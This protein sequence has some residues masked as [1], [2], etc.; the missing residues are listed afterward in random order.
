MAILETALLFTAILVSVGSALFLRSAIQHNEL[1]DRKLRDAEQKYRQEREARDSAED[2]LRRAAELHRQAQNEVCA[3]NDARAV[4]IQ[5]RDEANER[6]QH[7]EELRM[8]AERERDAANARVRVAEQARTRAEEEREAAT[9]ERDEAIQARKIAEENTRRAIQARFEAEDQ[10]R[11]ANER[12]QRAEDLQKQAE[13]NLR[14]AIQD[15]VLA[16]ARARSFENDAHLAREHASQAERACE[17]A[18]EQARLAAQA[19]KHAEDVRDA[20]LEQA[21]LANERANKA[22]QERD[23]ALAS[24]HRA[25][26]RA[27]RAEELRKQAERERDKANERAQRAERRARRARNA[28][29]LAKKQRDAANE[30]AEQA[31]REFAEPKRVSEPIPRVSPEPPSPKPPSGQG[32]ETNKPRQSN[33]EG[34]RKPRTS[35]SPLESR[36]G[37]RDHEPRLHIAYTTRSPKPEI[38]CVQ[39]Q[40]EWIL[41]VELPQEWL[42]QYTDL[43][44]FQNGMQLEG[45]DGYWRLNDTQGNLVVRSDK[46]SVWHT[47]LGERAKQ[48]LLFKLCGDRERGQRVGTV[49]RGWYLLVV[50]ES[51]Q[52][53]GYDPEGIAV[54]GYQAYCRFVDDYREICFQD[55]DGKSISLTPHVAQFTLDGSRLPDADESRGPLFGGTLPHLRAVNPDAWQ[56]V[57]TVVVGEEGRKRAEWRSMVFAPDTIQAQQNLPPAIVQ[58]KASWFFVRFYDT[59]DQLIESMDFRLARGLTEIQVNPPSP[60]P[61]EQGH[62]AASVKFYHAADCTIEP[63]LDIKTM[64]ADGITIAEIPPCAK[65]AKTCWNITTRDHEPIQVTILVERIWWA[66]GMQ[67]KTLSDSEWSDK[68]LALARAD[69]IN[70]TDKSLWIRLPEP[71][72]IDT[73]QVL[74][75]FAQE[76]MRS[77]ARGKGSERIASIRLN[78]FCDSESLRRIGESQ[79]VIR[80]DDS[81]AT[82]ANVRAQAKCRFCDFATDAAEKIY[83]HIELRHLD[84]IFQPLTYAEHRQR[85][86]DLPHRIAICL[87]TDCHYH[88]YSY[89]PIENVTDLIL[90][91]I[92]LEKHYDQDGHPRFEELSDV[93]KI[94]DRLPELIPDI[95]KCALHP[96]DWEKENPSKNDLLQHLKENHLN[97][98]YELD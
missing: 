69:F 95:R 49:S 71:R 86:P 62:S 89:S 64:S 12:A 87:R 9:R 44:V 33:N 76:T 96:C 83:S 90:Q 73:H 46:E 43:Q 16:D 55:S 26:E 14:L 53:E 58:W 38:T 20:A 23:D 59:N 15:K 63:P 48:P 77:L 60:L 1:A 13:E 42:E 74:V 3:A 19:Q 22:E 97:A 25:N 52:Y 65:Y 29:V 37:A 8:R 94:R 56:Q 72:W 30:R 4:A 21:R 41:R 98:L 5:G 51:W 54:P 78:D 10:T 66:V 88:A 45:T 92:R 84:A 32:T 11:L 50:P 34:A 18:K 47:H 93:K 27:Q 6:A 80:V 91:H 7:A 67:G 61:E 85:N 31:E 24:E 68:P 70:V 57:K 79:F 40:N 82:L 36:K 28:F 17:D 35:P 75:G 2:A 39:K 81:E